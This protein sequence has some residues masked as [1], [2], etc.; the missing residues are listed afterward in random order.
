MYEIDEIDRQKMRGL[1]VLLTKIARRLRA[2]E[3]QKEIE[4]VSEKT[5]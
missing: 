2:E 5:G 1:A 4:A 3:R